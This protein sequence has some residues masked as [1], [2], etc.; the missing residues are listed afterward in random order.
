MSHLPSEARK[1]LA[2]IG[3]KGGKKGG[4]TTGESKVR[5]DAEYYRAI[6]QKAAKA[7]KAKRTA[8]SASAAPFKNSGRSRGMN[9]GEK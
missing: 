7:R 2:K 6:G 4:K 8:S 9:K 3:A 5:G 1:Y